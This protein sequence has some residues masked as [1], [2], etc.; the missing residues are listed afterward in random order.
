MPTKAVDH[1][2]LLQDFEKREKLP[3]RQD[4]KLDSKMVAIFMG[5]EMP[6]RKRIKRKGSPGKST[7]KPMYHYHYKPS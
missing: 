4:I 2:F 1:G 3:P 7:C 5:R 6:P